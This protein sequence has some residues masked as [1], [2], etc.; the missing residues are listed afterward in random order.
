[1]DYKLKEIFLLFI[2]KI[3]LKS[4]LLFNI[5]NIGLFGV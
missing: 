5:T 2:A 1:M 3:G 4:Y